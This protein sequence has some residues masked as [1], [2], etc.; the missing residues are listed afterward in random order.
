M[1]SDDRWQPPFSSGTSDDGWQPPFADNEYQ[2]SQNEEPTTRAPLQPFD[3]AG[4]TP[5][6]IAAIPSVADTAIG[7][8][9]REVES[10]GTLEPAVGAVLSAASA[11]SAQAADAIAGD[12]LGRDELSRVVS[13]LRD[14]EAIKYADLVNSV[15]SHWK[16]AEKLDSEEFDTLVHSAVDVIAE[17]ANSNDKLGARQIVDAVLKITDASDSDLSALE[18]GNTMAQIKRYAGLIRRLRR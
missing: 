14:E 17:I 8:I 15:V 18:E 10:A 5:P 12:E 9:V 11:L 7:E 16:G 2:G 6:G 13:V 4:D 1:N 3:S